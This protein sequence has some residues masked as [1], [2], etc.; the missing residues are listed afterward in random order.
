MVVASS[1]LLVGRQ[2]IAGD[3]EGTQIETGALDA[4][5]PG[6]PSQLI[7]EQLIQV[8][9]TLLAIA[10]DYNFQIDNLWCRCSQPIEHL[11]QRPMQKC[12][13]V[14]TQPDR[15]GSLLDSH[16]IQSRWI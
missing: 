14:E 13:A 5:L 11:L 12:L 6:S 7:G 8:T 1:D 3:V 16:W 15:H 10:T 4:N 9:V 2:R